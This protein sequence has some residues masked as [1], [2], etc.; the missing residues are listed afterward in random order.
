[1]TRRY[2]LSFVN[3]GRVNGVAIVDVTEEEAA[4]A[5][6]DLDERFPQHQD[7]AEWVAAATRKAWAEDCNPGGDVEGV[8]ITELPLPADV[9]LNKF[10]RKPE[11]KQRG[12]I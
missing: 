8:D 11:L 10:M 4:L 2:W 7:G 9:P 3:P 5:K 6:V 1:M 12:L